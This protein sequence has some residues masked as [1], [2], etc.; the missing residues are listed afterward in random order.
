MP[1]TCHAMGCKAHV[2]PRLFMCRR[3]WRKL[4]KEA[5]RQI[6]TTYRP[7]QEVRKDPSREYLAVAQ[8]AIKLLAR[9]EGLICDQP[10]L[11][12]PLTLGGVS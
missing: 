12:A 3:H 6:W 10:D 11:L 4:P 8:H 5:Q 1:H 7:G 9:K 2:P